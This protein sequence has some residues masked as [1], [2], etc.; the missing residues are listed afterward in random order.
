MDTSAGSLITTAELAL[1]GC[2]MKVL[3]TGAAGF[4]GS[5]VAKRLRD[6]GWAV[7]S[8]DTQPVTIPGVESLTG[9]LLDQDAVERAT[10]GIDVV[11]H[12]A[13][14]G[15]VYLAADRPELAAA[16]N[17]TGTSHI[18]R[19]AARNGSRVVYASTWEVYGEPE[20]EPLDEDHPCRPDH[21]YNITKLAG[22]QMLMAACR[23]NGLS[24]LALRLGTAFGSGLRPNSVF[25]IFIDRARQGEP[26][27]I[28]GD[29]LQ[30]RQFTHA[31]DIAEA[32]RLAALSGASGIALNTVAPETTTI[33]ELAERV[34]HRYPTDLTFG[35]ARPG[36]V[37]PARVSAERI[38]QVL[39]WEP[40]TSFEAGLNELMDH[41]ES[42]G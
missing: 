22:E 9:D 42:E 23:L 28:A 3:V 39:G 31:S 12:I 37:P 24:G 29:G 11:C 27:T 1:G 36:D 26:I 16:V 8:F 34:V 38:R 41:V 15:D 19:A 40:M 13:A 33:K 6:E 21:P 7:R 35:P 14:I 25:R 17:V 5:H 32:F 4:L 30:G 20:Y 18:A 2:N 10:T